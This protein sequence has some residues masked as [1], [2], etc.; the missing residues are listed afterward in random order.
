MN[1]RLGFP[2]TRFRGA[3]LRPLGHATVGDYTRGP[4]QFLNYLFWAKNCVNNS[5]H[6]CSKTPEITSTLCSALGS[7]I[8]SHTEPQAPAFS[9]QAPKTSYEILAAIIAPAHITHGSRVTTKVHSSK[10]QAP[11]DLEAALIATISACPS[12]SLRS[13]L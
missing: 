13:S 9:S 2:N 3:L 11:I 4:N 8:K 12:G 7:R 6:S 10:R 1:P 5:A